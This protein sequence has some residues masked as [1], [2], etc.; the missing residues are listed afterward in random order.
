MAGAS[1]VY[2][3]PPLGASDGDFVRRNPYDTAIFSMDRMDVLHE[4]SGPQREAVA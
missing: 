1:A 3:I 2:I 4:G